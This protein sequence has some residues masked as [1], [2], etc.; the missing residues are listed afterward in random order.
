MDWTPLLKILGMIYP[1]FVAIGVLCAFD[2]VLKS[3]NVQGTIAWCICLVLFP[4][5]SIPVYMVFGGR[6]F[7]GYIKA[8]QKGELDINH[9][10]KDLNLKLKEFFLN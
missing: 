7:Y 9:I 3:R 4:I 5:I 10:G 8:R 2:A 6:K 1:F